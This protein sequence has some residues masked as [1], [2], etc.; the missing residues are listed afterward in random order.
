MQGYVRLRW[1]HTVVTP[2]EREIQLPAL[3]LV[4]LRR[5]GMLVKRPGPP[6]ISPNIYAFLDPDCDSLLGGLRR[7]I[8]NDISE[9]EWVQCRCKECRQ[10]Y[11]SFNRNHDVHWKKIRDRKRP[12]LREF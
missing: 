12:G 5:L 4:I 9:P 2:D 1:G 10:R 3:A 11:R 6:Q 7:M 8:G